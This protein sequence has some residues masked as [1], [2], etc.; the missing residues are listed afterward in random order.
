MTDINRL[1]VIGAGLMGHGIALSCAQAGIAV[2]IQDPDADMRA[3]VDERIRAS[4][5]TIDA[6][7]DIASQIRIEAELPVAVRTAD[8]VIEAVPE[9][10]DLKQAIFATVAKYAP[11]HAILATNTSSIPITTVMNKLTTHHRHRALGT[12]WFHPP[13]QMP[14]VEVIR[15]KWTDDATI[16]TT[17]AVLK[18]IGKTPVIVAKDIPG[19]I[20]NR[21]QHALW[22]E[23]IN[24]VANGVC[25][26]E[27]VDTVVKN[28]FGRRLAILGPLENVDLVGTDLTLAIHEQLLPDLDSKANGAPSPLLTSLVAQGCLGMKSGSGFREWSTEEA[29]RTKKRLAT[30]LRKLEAILEQKEPPKSV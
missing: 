22:R 7:P 30:H 27:A 29:E 17:V 1:T 21:L 19:F 8:L 10:V 12:H 14:L 5:T 11:A 24:L 18:H 28:S 6:D 25:D 2:T 20:G 9:K 15:A 4:L 13:H 3:S 23:A 16:A 26:A